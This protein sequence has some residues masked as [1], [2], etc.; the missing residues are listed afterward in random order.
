MSSGK[1][2]LSLK[3]FK[4]LGLDKQ[5]GKKRKSGKRFS[6]DHIESSLA[7]QDKSSNRSSKY[8]A[9]KT[10]VDGITFD[11]KFEAERYSILKIMEK[12]G[13]IHSLELQVKFSIS[14]NDMKICDYV[15]DFVYFENEKRIVEDAKGVKTP[16]YK[17]KKKL[18]KAVLGIDILETFKSKK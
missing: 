15:A 7:E 1:D 10:T 8:N 18:M 5:I 9:R 13:L 12:G 11:S 3:E 2:R 17:L 16:E 4:D 14:I 6:S